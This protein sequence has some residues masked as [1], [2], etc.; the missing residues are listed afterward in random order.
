MMMIYGLIHILPI[1]TCGKEKYQST[2]NTKIG[3]KRKMK[4]CPDE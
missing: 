1:R 2:D 3:M 4:S